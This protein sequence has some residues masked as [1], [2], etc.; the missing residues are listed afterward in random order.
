MLSMGPL[1]SLFWTSG[2]IYSGFQT[3]SGQPFL[4]LVEEIF[5]SWV[6]PRVSHTIC[7]NFR[8]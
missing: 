6:R 4:Y 2:D 3:Q 8:A 7:I 1:I 5:F